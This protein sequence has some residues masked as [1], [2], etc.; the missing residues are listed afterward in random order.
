MNEAKRQ[1]SPESKTPHFDP[2]IHKAEMDTDIGANTEKE[3]SFVANIESRTP[4][5]MTKDVS[6]VIDTSA[7]SDKEDTPVEQARPR[8]SSKRLSRI[9]DSVDALDAFEEEIEKIGGLIPDTTEIQ[10]PVKTK[11]QNKGPAK[12]AESKNISRVVKKDTNASTKGGS[13]SKDTNVSQSTSRPSISRPRATKANPQ[14]ETIKTQKR[15]TSGSAATGPS[16]RKS[17]DALKKRVSSVHKAPFQPTKST[18]AP[19]KAAFKLPGEAVARK[20][21]EQRE[22][23]QK[24]E[25]TEPPKQ[26]TLKARPKP[27]RLSHA[28]EI[29]LTAAA[30]ARLSM[31]RGEPLPKTSSINGT[32][33]PK[34]H[35]RANSMAPSDKSQPMSRLSVAKRTNA[36]P[37]AN[38]SASH[39]P[40]MTA[41]TTTPTSEDLVHQKVKGKQVFGRARA[42]LEERDKAKKDK[43]EAA[44]KARA[45]AAERGRLASREWAEKQK[46]R[47]MEAQKA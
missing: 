36:P 46:L 28:P 38:T 37:S 19:T 21:K 29:K 47:K 18:K 5:R 39:A 2:Q 33:A 11:K 23:R 41:S 31:A 13:T 20:L 40:S 30:K 7:S 24:R 22:E 15:E 3:D 8:S 32:T 44:K 35:T 27:T 34:P 12:G 25:E 14:V 4:A 43:E 42:E 17:P 45:E 9:E 6:L 26:Q 1:L 16:M 10:S